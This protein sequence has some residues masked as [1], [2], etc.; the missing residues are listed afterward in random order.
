MN[1]GVKWCIFFQDT[2]S[3][4]FNTIAASLGVSAICNF[5]VNTLTCPR[6]AKA[7]MG[8]IVKLKNVDGKRS[9]TINVEYNQLDPLLRANS[10][11][12][13]DT[14][15][16]NGFSPFPGNTNQLIF[17]MEPYVATLNN[18]KGIMGEFVNPKY[19]DETRTNFKKP[20]RL[21]CMMQDYPKVLEASAKVGFTTV[22]SW[23]AYSPCK[24]NVEDAAIAARSSI[25]PSCAFS[26]ESDHYNSTNE[27]LRRHKVN[28]ARGKLQ[29]FQ[30]VSAIVGPRIVMDPSTAIFPCEIQDCFPTPEK[31]KISARSTLILEGDVKVYGLNLDGALHLTAV[32][33]T[34][35]SVFSKPEL[36]IRNDGHI[37]K[38][39]DNLGH[40]S[41]IDRMRG[42][43]I[44]KKDTEIISTEHVF[45]QDKEL[46]ASCSGDYVY[47]GNGIILADFYDP[48][49]FEELSSQVCSSCYS[50]CFL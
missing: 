8:A 46:V 32:P 25:P 39:I 23:L 2:N 17:R 19:A 35:L 1:Y 24:N 10:F 13:G 37:I 5:E 33:G 4:A 11:A 36:C 22:P 28:V 38:A 49:F 6:V 42:Y 30:G 9:V 48:S 27:I 41:E 31:V 50:S 45:K 20:T 34:R 16:F 40:A 26:S 43:V 29:T 47:T 18:T 7:A 3:L 21:E 44:E 15:G 14:N 12:E